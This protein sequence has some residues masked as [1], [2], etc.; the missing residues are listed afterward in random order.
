MGVPD[1][2]GKPWVADLALQ[3]LIDALWN[4]RVD[5][6][7][8]SYEEISRASRTGQVFKGRPAAGTSGPGF[9]SKSSVGAL[10][11]STRVPDF[12]ALQKV[13]AA[14]VTHRYP[15]HGGMHKRSVDAST[16]RFLG[17]W[18]EA[19]K[20]L[21]PS[22]YPRVQ[23]LRE[24]GARYHRLAEAY[25]AIERFEE[26][27]YLPKPPE[28]SRTPSEQLFDDTPPTW[29]EELEELRRRWL[30]V[31]RMSEVLFGPDHPDTVE[32]WKRAPANGRF[33]DGWGPPRDVFGLSDEA[34][35]P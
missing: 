20:R 24:T 16:Q 4:L 6:G 12:A 15:V 23:S 17:L 14:I 26:E 34:P 1:W 30:D 33:A 2:S 25:E 7:W 22:E 5:H 31:A 21:K 29:L 3:R 8:P 35:N 28:P 13:V 19:A 10:M 32:A 9:I 27:R 11:T 18:S